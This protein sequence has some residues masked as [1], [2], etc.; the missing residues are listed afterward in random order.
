MNLP[1]ELAPAYAGTAAT[2]LGTALSIVGV[3]TPLLQFVLLV[4]SI[5][6][7][8]LTGW[9]TYKKVRA[10]NVRAEAVVAAQAVKAVAV[11]AAEAV[12]AV[13]AVASKVVDAQAV[14]ASKVVDAQALVTATA[15]V[16]T[17][18]ASHDGPQI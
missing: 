17:K 13:E 9:W 16:E 7:G 8:V 11:V 12:K 14:V 1:P 10:E 18:E 5:F 2:W 15:L 3:V 4:T 6:V